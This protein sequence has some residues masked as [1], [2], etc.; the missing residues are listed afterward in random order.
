MEQKGIFK[1]NEVTREDALRKR[2]LEYE[3]NLIGV[4]PKRRYI[5][6]CYY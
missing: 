5:V 1:K 3:E 2:A 6:I 4:D